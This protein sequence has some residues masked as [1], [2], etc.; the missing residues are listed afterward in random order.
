M[1]SIVIYLA[2]KTWVQSIVVRVIPKLQEINEFTTDPKGSL[3]LD[4]QH[5]K[6]DWS[7]NSLSKWSQYK[8]CSSTLSLTSWLPV[9]I[10]GGSL[11]VTFDYDSLTYFS[12]FYLEKAWVHTWG[13]RWQKLLS[14]RKLILVDCTKEAVDQHTYLGDEKNWSNSLVNYHIPI[15]QQTA[16]YVRPLALQMLQCLAGK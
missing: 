1:H 14:R 6:C 12:F 7:S 10:E 4:T 9:A 15:Y 11:R 16:V 2:R 3:S 8:E 13:Q 5:Y